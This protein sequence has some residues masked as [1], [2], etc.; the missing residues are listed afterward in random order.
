M[1]KLLFMSAC[2]AGLVAFGEGEEI[3][4]PFNRTG[5][6]TYAI[7]TDKIGE[8]NSIGQTP[9]QAGEQTSGFLFFYQSAGGSTDGSMVKGYGLGENL[10]PFEYNMPCGLPNYFESI[11]GVETQAKYLELS[12]EGG[13]LWRSA[14]EVDREYDPWTFG[15]GISLSDLAG[16]EMSVYVDTMVQFT[17]TEDGNAP[18]TDPADKLAIWLNVASGEGENATSTTNLCVLANGIANE[19]GDPFLEAQT[20]IFDKQNIQPGVWYRLTVK[21]IPNLTVGDYPRPAFMIYLDGELLKTGTPACNEEFLALFEDLDEKIVAANAQG[22]LF[23]SLDL[24]SQDPYFYGVGFKGS[25][26][27]DDLVITSEEPNFLTT[28]TLDFTLSWGEGVSAVSYT[29]NGGEPTAAVSGVA[30][31]VPANAA[32]TITATPVN[33]WYQITGGTESFTI[34]AATT[35]EITAALVASPF[36]EGGV[37]SDIKAWADAKE[38]SLDA[39]K[40]DKAKAFKSYLMNTA[41]DADPQIK[42]TAIEQVDTGWKI[43]VQ[44]TTSDDSTINLGTINGQL[45]VKTAQN[46]AGLA[47][48]TPAV[49]QYTLDAAGNAVI[50]VTGDNKNFMRA[51]VGLPV[52][53]TPPVAE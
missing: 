51:T 23:V 25:G 52:P 34:T 50:T 31:Q 37:T 5:F 43:T 2:V 48:A 40:A 19:F 15:T 10:P 16:E 44:G 6:E 11:K 36:P 12:T 26:A 18:T 35:R 17:P 38:I 45:Q 27:I 4:G 14:T 21:V 9:T 3:W 13:T 49:Y 8:K 7:G 32:V 1:K 20:Y 39:I 30:V 53:T 41:L 29:I 47:D 46:L 28:T 42:I 22:G 33:D 24:N